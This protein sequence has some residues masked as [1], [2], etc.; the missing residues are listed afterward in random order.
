MG[1][2]KPLKDGDEVITVTRTWYPTGQDQ[3]IA[4]EETWHL[5]CWPGRKLVREGEHT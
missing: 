1:C 5:N 3:R 2:S 4:H